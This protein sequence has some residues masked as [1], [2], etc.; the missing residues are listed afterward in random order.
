MSNPILEVVNEGAGAGGVPS[1]LCLISVWGQVSIAA[2]LG[3]LGEELSRMW[4]NTGDLSKGQSPS[5]SCDYRRLA[6]TSGCVMFLPLPTVLLSTNLLPAFQ[7]QWIKPS[8][9]SSWRR[10]WSLGSPF[11]FAAPWTKDPVLSRTS[12]TKERRPNPSTKKPQMPPRP[13]GT[14][15]R[16]ARS[17]RDN[18]T[19][20][21]PTEPT[22]PNTWAQAT[23]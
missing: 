10:R 23:H 17:T 7:P 11:C 5:P 19:A 9:L 1:L 22:F 18:I 6:V 16:P 8:S 20:R 2:L 4:G 13:F 15:P 12:F 14:C 21:P 3:S